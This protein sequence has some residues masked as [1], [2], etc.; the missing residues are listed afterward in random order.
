MLRHRP[1]G[2]SEFVPAFRQLMDPFLSE[3]HLEGHAVSTDGHRWP[4]PSTQ[5][6]ERIESAQDVQMPQN[7]GNYFVESFI[8]GCF[9]H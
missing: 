1:H 6:F 9:V 2:S 8:V 3:R 5:E 4:F 7:M